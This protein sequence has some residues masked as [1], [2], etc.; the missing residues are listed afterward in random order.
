MFINSFPQDLTCE[1]VPAADVISGLKI[2]CIE[3][4]TT[5]CGCSVINAFIISFI[6]VADASFNFDFYNCNL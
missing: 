3:S 2:V 1:T 5:T 6:Q 4:I